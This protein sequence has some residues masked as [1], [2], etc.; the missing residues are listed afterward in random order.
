M[1]MIYLPW[2]GI[3]FEGNDIRKRNDY[4]VS[5]IVTS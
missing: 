1:S 4:I 2:V 3:W 5:M